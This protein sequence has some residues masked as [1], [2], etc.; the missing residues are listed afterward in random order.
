MGTK[1]VLVMRGYFIGP[2]VTLLKNWSMTRRLAAENIQTRNEKVW[3][4]KFLTNK[5]YIVE[6]R[7]CIK[8]NIFTE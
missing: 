6:K 7:K 2:K 8:E 1:S 3:K 4:T 5:K